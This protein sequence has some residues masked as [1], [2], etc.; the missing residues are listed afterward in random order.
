MRLNGDVRKKGEVMSTGAQQIINVLGAIVLG[1]LGWWS[2][3]IWSSVQTMQSQI[4]TLNVELARN[5][6]PRV[7]MQNN[8][9]RIYSKLDTIEKQVRK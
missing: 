8:L 1:F 6:A 2:N 9:D 3:N 4:T 5:Y 7:E